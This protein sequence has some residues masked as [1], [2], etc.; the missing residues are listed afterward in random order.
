[1]LQLSSSQRRGAPFQAL[2]L[3]GGTNSSRL[4][5][6]AGWNALAKSKFNQ[7]SWARGY[8]PRMELLTDLKNMA[9]CQEWE[10]QDFNFL[11]HILGKSRSAQ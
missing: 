10:K 2:A 1:M 8:D 11:K 9:V 3:G 7:I 4:F 6:P 5:T